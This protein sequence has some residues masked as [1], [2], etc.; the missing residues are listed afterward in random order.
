MSLCLICRWSTS[1]KPKNTSGN[2][3]SQWK[4]R[5][6]GRWAKLLDLGDQVPFLVVVERGVE[7]LRVAQV[8]MFAHFTRFV[9]CGQPEM[10]GHK[11]VENDLVS[12]QAT[13]R[14]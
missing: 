9:A 8:E 2:S 6:S 1:M 13:A 7:P 4:K 11:Q 10:L 12:S 14:A 3:I 5:R